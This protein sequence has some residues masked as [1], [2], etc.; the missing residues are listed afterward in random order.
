MKVSSVQFIVGKY[1]QVD[2]KSKSRKREIVFP[3]Q[4]LAYICMELLPY[5]YSDLGKR[6]NLHHTTIMNHYK[7][8]SE[9]LNKDDT[10]KS[11]IKNIN[12]IIEVMKEILASE[13][14]RRKLI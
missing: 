8:V 13:K 9:K 4:V 12:K 3:R 2:M 5:S 11:D 14:Y 10:L 1:Y 7:R 6:L